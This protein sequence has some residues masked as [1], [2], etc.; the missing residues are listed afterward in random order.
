MLLKSGNNHF[1]TVEGP[2]TVATVYRPEDEPDQSNYS[3]NWNNFNCTVCGNDL[4]TKFHAYTL[5]WSESEIVWSL[6]GIDIHRYVVGRSISKPFLPLAIATYREDGYEPHQDWE[7]NQL[8]IQSVVVRQKRPIESAPAKVEYEDLLFDNFT[9]DGRPRADFWRLHRGKRTPDRAIIQRA[10]TWYDPDCVDVSNGS[11]RI[12][13]SQ[14]ASTEYNYSLGRIDSIG[15]WNILFGEVEWRMK[16]YNFRGGMQALH[17]TVSE[18][19]PGPSLPCSED[20]PRIVFDISHFSIIETRYY[21]DGVDYAQKLHERYME[22]IGTQILGEFH[23]YLIRWTETHVTWHIDGKQ[24]FTLRKTTDQKFPSKP[25]HVSMTP[26]INQYLTPSN[27]SSDEHETYP[28]WRSVVMEID[29]YLSFR[30]GKCQKARRKAKRPKK[31]PM[32]KM[33]PAMVRRMVRMLTIGKAHH[34]FRSVANALQLDES[35]VRSHLQDR[36]IKCFKKIKRNLIPETQK[37][38][39]RKCAMNLRKTIRMSDVPNM[40]FLDECYICVGKYFNYQNERCY[41]YSLETISDGKK[42]KQFP[43]QLCVRWFLAPFLFPVDLPSLFEVRFQPEPAYLQGQ[44]PKTDAGGPPLRSGS[45]FGDFV[46]GQSTVPRGS[47][48]AGLFERKMPCFIPNADIPP[49]SPI[50]IPSIIVCGSLLKE[51][52]NKHGLISSFDRLAKILKDEWEAI[53]QQVIQDSINS[54]MSRVRKVEKARGSHIE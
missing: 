24:I 23:T 11:L 14:N 17:L 40:L 8:V 39:R 26:L 25:M 19:D 22:F 51:R 33:T 38:A 20:V 48:C 32:R 45:K 18:C 27:P 34:S 1:K 9:N 41:G 54:W 29:Y 44:L 42:F 21:F 47:N 28:S 53:S 35:T 6:D 2:K 4:A 5:R 36:N 46:S 12:M 7:K 50:S 16:I 3:R 52:V 49:N 10:S 15:R 43:R 31:Q 37:E 13:V 30:I